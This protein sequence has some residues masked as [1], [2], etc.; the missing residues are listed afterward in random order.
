MDINPHFKKI[1]KKIVAC[2][3][4]QTHIQICLLFSQLY[5]I[6]ITWHSYQLNFVSV[7][8]RTKQC[9]VCQIS[10][11]RRSRKSWSVHQRFQSVHFGTMNRNPR[12][13]SIHQIHSWTTGA[14][15]N[16]LIVNTNILYCLQTSLLLL[17]CSLSTIPKGTS[18]DQMFSFSFEMFYSSTL[19]C[20]CIINTDK[21]LHIVIWR[22]C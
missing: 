3:Y 18:T 1:I 12:T 11:R 2:T 19:E 20:H 14:A 8:F 17:F 4:T 6:N 22:W 10:S 7:L 15:V 13:A 9:C 16:S 5:L 21:R